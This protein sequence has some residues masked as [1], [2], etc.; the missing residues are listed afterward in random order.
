MDLEVRGRNQRNRRR[1]TKPSLVQAEAIRSV[2]APPPPPPAP[3]FVPYDSGAAEGQQW[4]PS[5]QPKLRVEG[6]LTGSVA[7]SSGCRWTQA[8]TGPLSRAVKKIDWWRRGLPAAGLVDNFHAAFLARWPAPLSL[9]ETHSSSLSI[10]TRSSPPALPLVVSAFPPW[11]APP[12]RQKT[13]GMEEENM[14]NREGEKNPAGSQAETLLGYLLVT[15]E[16]VNFTLI[17]DNDRLM[18]KILHSRSRRI[19]KQDRVWLSTLS[20]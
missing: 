7:D 3:P 8:S 15:A 16:V 19:L 4:R 10:P 1:K 12:H 20:S 17:R 13:A 14:S 9:Y 5:F 11:T 6:S 2:Q 18:D